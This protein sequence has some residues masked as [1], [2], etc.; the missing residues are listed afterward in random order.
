MIKIRK[1]TQDDIPSIIKIESL[2]FKYPYLSIVFYN[3]IG[4][5]FYV[6]EL[7]DRV[8]GYAIGDAKRHLIV[9][10]AVHP[11][12]RRLGIGRALMNAILKNMHDYAILQ[13][14]MSNKEAIKFYK[15]LGFVEKELLK[16]YYID[17]E[18]A[19]LMFKSL[20]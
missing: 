12:Y 9:S 7:N 5:N 10:I 16:R 1:C 8:V 20:D 18:D 17:G 14:R 3:Y 19:I 11:D 15:N 2:S 4:K 13:V 6:G